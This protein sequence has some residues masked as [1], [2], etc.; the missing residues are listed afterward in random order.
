MRKLKHL[1]HR[2]SAL[3]EAMVALVLLSVGLIGLAAL[4]A[5]ALAASGTAIRRSQAIGLAGSMADLI[6][7]NARGLAAY[8]GPAADPACSA[9]SPA[10]RAAGDLAWWQREI[11]RTLPGGTGS[12][13]I[14]MAVL[15]PA[16]TVTLLWHEPS[17]TDPVSL[18]LRF[19][20]RPY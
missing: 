2:G 10:E 14:D 17:A 11:E 4:Q 15:P 19:R 16:I 12:V 5:D 8:R 7:A 9:C 13:A 18:S 6:R 20:Q 3:I 1:H